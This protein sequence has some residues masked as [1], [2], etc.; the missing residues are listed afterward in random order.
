MAFLELF[1]ETLD[2]N[3]TENY[4]LSLQAGPD[5]FSFCLLD[6]LRNKMV[7][8]RSHEPEENKYLNAGNI[9]EIIEKDDFLIKPFRG[10]R[11]VLP[12]PKMTLVPSALFDPA[13]KD[14]F[15]ALNHRIEDGRT[16]LVNK[17]EDPDTYII[18]SVLSGLK[19]VLEI[20]YPQVY[21][22]VHMVPLL[23]HIAGARK[24]HVNYIHIHTERDYFNLIVF[25]GEHLKFCNTFY[26]RSV[27]DIMY[28]VFNVFS[29]LG[30]K[31]DETVHISGIKS[32][33]NELSS[34]LK[35]YVSNIKFSSPRGNFTFSY[36]FG[37]IEI[38]R[39]LTLFNSL[40]CG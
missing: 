10:I 21:P 35:E 32:D 33:N 23:N 4:E 13:R 26:Y 38:H 20:H 19:D 24:N 17:C 8:L 9:K 16:V 40:N 18:F 12:T 2:I 7:L 39:H 25:H 27:T 22:F 36:V 29:K 37:D 15:F 28:F 1:D 14:D 3:S 11:I 34:S 31:Q 5:G 30:I 6:T